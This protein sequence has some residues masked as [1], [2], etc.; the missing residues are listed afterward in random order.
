MAMDKIIKQMR[1]K[2]LVEIRC[3]GKA[4]PVFDFIEL[5]ANSEP[6]ETDED[7]WTLRLWL[8]RN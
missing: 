6:Y 3:N 7:W 1:E 8:M 2:G 5:L 4:K